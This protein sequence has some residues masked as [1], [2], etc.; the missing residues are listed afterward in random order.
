MATDFKN[1]LD[2][3]GLRTNLP[4]DKIADRNAS[5]CRNMDFSILGQMQTRKG[6]RIFGDETT[7]IGQITRGYLYK[8]NFGT[9]KRIHIRVKDDESNTIVQWFNPSNDDNT[10][11]KWETL[12]GGQTTGKVFGFAPFN[13]SDKNELW[14][15]NGS[16]NMTKWDGCTGLVDSVTNN[17]IV[18]KET[19]ASEGF[20]TSSGDIMVDGTEYAYTGTSGSTFT[21]VTPDPTTQNP[22]ENSGVAQSPDDSTYSGHPKGNILLTAGAR[23]WVAGLEDKPSTLYYSK[24]ADATNFSAATNPDDAGIEDFP[25]GGGPITLLDSKDNQKIIVHKEDGLAI[26]R[27][28]YTATAK[29]P[30]LDTITLADDTGATNQKAGAGLNRTAYFVTEV[31]G[32]KSLA[33]AAEGTD[34]VMSS[35]SDV[36]LPTVRDFD[37]DD[38]SA[39]YWPYKRV[40]KVACKSNSDQLH[41]D[42][43]ISYY[44]QM[45]NEGIEVIDISI[46]DDFVG[47][48]TISGNNLYAHSSVTPNTYLYEAQYSDDGAS[49]EHVWQSK[50]FTFGEPAK[51]KEFNTVYLEGGIRAH[52]KI[53]VSVLYGILGNDDQN[54][55]TISWDDDFVSEQEVSALG[56][57]V[58]GSV[59]LGASSA[60][61]QDSRIFGVP[62]HVDVN[63]STRYKIKVETI[64]D[65]ETTNES[66]WFISNLATNPT[67]KNIDYNKMINT[68]V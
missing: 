32:L 35:M 41:N 4:A 59:S 42:R 38:A 19:I 45:G 30:Y 22:A 56:Y 40:I 21:G 68:N 29:I 26:F 5:E 58:I 62:I 61:I 48:W 10:D 24:V 33:R 6:K 46:D 44:L 20:D 60:D 2:L 43:V 64:Y 55:K 54:D 66:Y 49:I 51:G 15:C 27:L 53:K 14:F 16:N 63:K 57:D 50:E 11:G 9:L 36:I 12:L 37:F 8:K 17:T 47:D 65:S 31:E 39:I 13:Q 28:E 52:T 34:I 67:L 18:I 23:L 3:G 1:I 7:G 25:D